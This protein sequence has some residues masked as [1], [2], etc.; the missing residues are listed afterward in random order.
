MWDPEQCICVLAH[1]RAGCGPGGHI[2]A[3]II[4]QGKSKKPQRELDCCL[5]KRKTI[6]ALVEVC[7]RMT[8][9]HFQRHSL[10]KCFHTPSFIGTQNHK[11]TGRGCETQT[12]SGICTS[13]SSHK[14]LKQLQT[15]ALGIMSTLNRAWS[16]PIGKQQRDT[17]AT[18]HQHHHFP[19]RLQILILH[20]HKQPQLQPLLQTQAELHPQPWESPQAGVLCPQRG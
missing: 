2:K 5:T 1:H 11:G 19:H 18:R 3:N 20:Q 13:C 8:S 4:L 14:R 10:F 7:A 9:G 12:L 6:A 17:V 16:L 15:A